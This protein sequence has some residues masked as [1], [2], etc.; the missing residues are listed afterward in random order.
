ME[1]P[2]RSH[3]CRCS[4]CEG[5]AAVGVLPRRGRRLLLE[6][7]RSA[8]TAYPRLGDATLVVAAATCP[9]WVNRAPRLGPTP[10][11][12]VMGPLLPRPLPASRTP[13]PVDKTLGSRHA[14][15][16]GREERKNEMRGR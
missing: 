11:D 10:E 5:A 12:A 3:L 14:R 8:T 7:A 6:D 2:R 13:P 1:V 15:E 4:V 9:Q 16:V